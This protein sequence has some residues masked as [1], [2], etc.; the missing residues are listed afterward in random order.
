MGVDQHR[1]HA[2][3]AVV[4]NEA[5]SAH[6]RGKIVNS[7]RTLDR[8]LTRVLVAKIEL[9]VF[10]LWRQLIPIIQRLH[11]H[12]ANRRMTLTQQI[13]NQVAADKA[14]ATANDNSL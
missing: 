1:K 6:V 8:I 10:G 9:K 13:S 14:A 2:Q 3:R 4:F 11:V 5:H 12:G 7:A